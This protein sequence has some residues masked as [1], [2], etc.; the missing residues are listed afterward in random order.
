MTFNC[1]LNYGTRDLKKKICAFFNIPEYTQWK[2]LSLLMWTSVTFKHRL[3]L[4]AEC[5]DGL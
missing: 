2:A 3:Q 1:L 5:Q 4:K